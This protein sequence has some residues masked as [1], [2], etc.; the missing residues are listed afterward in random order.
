M[1]GARFNASPGLPPPPALAKLKPIS[2]PAGF[3][4]NGAGGNAG[5]WPADAAAPGAENGIDALN[6]LCMLGGRFA[7][8]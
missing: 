2:P 8:K 7:D 1:N 3:T 5:N 4:P 6:T